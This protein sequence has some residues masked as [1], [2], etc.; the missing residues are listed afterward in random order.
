MWFVD[1]DDDRWYRRCRPFR[2]WFLAYFLEQETAMF[3]FTR[4]YRIP[5]CLPSVNDKGE[6]DEQRGLVDFRKEFASL[7]VLPD[8]LDASPG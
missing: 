5:A 3:S 2:L 8:T 7:D 1:F 6:I 4:Q